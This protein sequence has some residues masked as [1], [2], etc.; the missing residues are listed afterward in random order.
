LK[1]FANDGI[2][3]IGRGAF[4]RLPTCILAHRIRT[5]LIDIAKL[6]EIKAKLLH[7]NRAFIP[8]AD[9]Y[10][11]WLLRAAITKWA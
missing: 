8:N 9:S 2:N 7:D 10:I 11:G 6:D 1:Q 4:V 3:R 5:R